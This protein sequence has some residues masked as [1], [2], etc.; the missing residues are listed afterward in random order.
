[1]WIV[2]WPLVFAFAA[3]AS[4]APVG[5]S[6]YGIVFDAGSSG[7]RI[8][9]YTWRTG[10]GGSKDA[11]DLV[12]DELL[13]I[14]PGLSAYKDRPS[15]AGASLEPLLAFARSKIPA[16]LIASTPMFLMATA[17]LRLVGEATKDAILASVCGYLGSTGFLFR[18]EWATLLD[19]RDEGLYG[20]VTVNY[21]LDALYPGGAQ[22]AGTI[23][24][25]GGSVQ[26]VF[27]TP[28]VAPSSAPAE[29]SQRLDFG[30]RSH[31][32]HVK[33]HLGLGLDS[34]RTS[35]LDLVAQRPGEPH[36]CLPIGASVTHKG[37]V[38]QGAGDYRRCKKLTKRLFDGEACSYG[39][40]MCSFGG[41]Y[42]PPL[43]KR[44]Y[45]FSY[46]FDRTA[47]IGLLDQKPVTF[48]AAEMSRDDIERAAKAVCSLD[49]AGAA[50]RFAATN[51]A[52]KAANFCG[53]TVYIAALLD[54]LGFD[55][56]STMT[57]TNKIKDVE[58]V[59]TLGA[60]LAQSSALASGAS[61]SH[62]G[63]LSWLALAATLA[64]LWYFC[65][66]PGSRPSG[67]PRLYNRPPP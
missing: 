25:G 10:G 23:D 17:G 27:P 11:F 34:A 21:L 16:E 36:P 63:A 38:V 66:G 64:G 58:L 19:G 5:K 60:M 42:Q 15:E 3:L 9:V 59:W 40:R 54:A 62:F 52:A 33:S 46:M 4:A 29:L 67:P 8:H 6:H 48:G 35:L 32:L 26:I 2:W 30:G 65:L 7:T 20:W 24:L 47:A 56:R 43:P 22:P 41:V 28:A 13:K 55:E 31:A 57:M 51:D 44:F 37:S 1:M 14:K 18:C 53:D 12:S 50:A 49:Q 39:E 61:G 45:G